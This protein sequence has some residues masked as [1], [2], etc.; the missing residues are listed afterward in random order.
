MWNKKPPQTRSKMCTERLLEGKELLGFPFEGYVSLHAQPREFLRESE[1]QSE[2]E[3]TEQCQAVSSSKR[4]LAPLS[5]QAEH[6]PSR[7]P[8]WIYQPSASK[9]GGAG[10]A[11]PRGG[12]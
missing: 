4:I 12:H 3:K 1:L 7:P 6:L 9:A 10:P 11:P 8:R 5:P 2:F